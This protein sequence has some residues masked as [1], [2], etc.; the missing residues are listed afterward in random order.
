MRRTLI[1]LVLVVAL[2]GTA[3]AAGAP[4]A[5]APPDLRIPL[6]TPLEQALASGTVVGPH[7]ARASL[8]RVDPDD[9]D[10]IVLGV[11]SDG[12]GTYR[13]AWSVL[14]TDGHPI[15]GT[16]ALVVRSAEPVAPPIAP[17]GSDGVGLVG[18]IARL[19]VLLGVLG[20]L[21][22]A[23]TREWVLGTALRQGGIA[24][25]G[26]GDADGHRARSAFAA[27]APVRAWWRAWWALEIAW[28]AGL[29]MALPAQAA[30][31]GIGTAGL[32][33]LLGDTRWGTAWIGLA[34]LAGIAA[35]AG[36]IVRRGDA[37]PSPGATRATALVAPGVIGAIVL[38]WSGHA[39]TGTDA[40]L[41]IML[42][43]LHGWATAVWLGGIL[44]L[45]VLAIPLLRALAPDDRV[46]LGAGIVVR[47]SA[48]AMAAVVVLVV[49]G[50][51]RALA[52]L[53]SPSALW[54]TAYG[55]ALVVKLAI[56]AVM[57]AVAAWNRWVL[58]PRLERAAL[59]IAPGG[60]A[61][62]GALRISMR[63]ELVLALAVL[64]AVA[65]LVSVPPPV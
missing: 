40:T 5:T 31:L 63:A 45:A 56:F 29:A 10:A 28:L 15:A 11:P 1:T 64:A 37:S 17:R 50:V 23:V 9:P 41:G 8:A 55:A 2:G 4:I 7:G 62:L 44:M 12:A 3:L 32:G 59:G 22:M 46:R 34:I 43:V 6:G 18:I 42:D 54:T 14:T 24:P 20:T 65:V 19:L 38:S 61:S 49:T 16:Q 33:T 21:G 53:P 51:Y 39:S 58:H 27:D 25:P 60:T 52:E 47:F 48:V 30:R 13:A 57:L 36:V 35:T 26:D